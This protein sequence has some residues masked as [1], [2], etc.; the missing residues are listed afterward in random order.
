MS[1][2]KA[3]EY[4][5][6]HKVIQFIKSQDV[7]NSVV[8]N[9][10]KKQL[11]LP[12]EDLAEKRIL[13][14]PTTFPDLQLDDTMQSY[15]E[16]IPEEPQSQLV[17]LIQAGAAS[18]GYFEGDVV[19]HKVITKYMVRKGQG[20]AQLTYAKQKG[21]SRLGSRIRLQQGL[22]FFKEINEKLDEW[23]NE[24]DQ[25]E[26]IFISCPIRL[27]N[28]IYGGKTQPPF[29]RDDVRIRKIP[30]S[31][32]KPSYKELKRIHFMLNAGVVSSE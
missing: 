21:K 20:K 1:L 19:L 16:K 12:S 9:H 24:I 14:L 5:P 7:G 31:T 32:H 25:V 2:K 27:M 26:S 23:K 28:E 6:Y 8:F 11:I 29:L 15:R 10:E 13:T 17:I 18:L 3:I 4:I 30:F 22:L